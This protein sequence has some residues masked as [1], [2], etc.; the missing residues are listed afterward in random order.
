MED[1]QQVPGCNWPQ[2]LNYINIAEKITNVEKKIEKDEKNCV[3]YVKCVKRERERN[4]CVKEDEIIV[5]KGM[6]KGV[7]IDEK[8]YEERW[9][10]CAK[11]N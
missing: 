10:N 7:N 1:T 8:M 6:K 3:E 5:W 4:N 11:R 2:D 9:K